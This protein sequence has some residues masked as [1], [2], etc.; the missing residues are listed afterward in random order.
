MCTSSFSRLSEH[1]HFQSS[2]TVNA[3]QIVQSYRFLL[4]IQKT[5]SDEW[6]RDWENFPNQKLWLIDVQLLR[7]DPRTFYL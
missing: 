1:V 4:S 3:W 7:P 5:H 6:L 2:A